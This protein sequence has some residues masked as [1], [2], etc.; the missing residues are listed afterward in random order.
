M[1]QYK[2]IEWLDDKKA[3]RL[4]D[5][6]VLPDTIAFKDLDTVESVA[7]A[8]RN[9]TV[10]G[11]PAIGVTAAYGL[12]I[13]AWLEPSDE[14]GSVQRAVNSAAATLRAARPTAVNLAWALAEVERRVTEAPVKSAADFRAAL[15]ETANDMA[16]EDIA[17]NRAIGQAAMALMP[18]E[19]VTFIHHCNTGSLATVEYGTALGVIRAAHDSGLDVIVF[20]DET[21]PRFQGAR[22]TCWELQNEGIRHRLIVDGA[23]SHVMQRF[24]VDMCMVGTDRVAANGD[25]A[26]KVG[27]C[28]LAAAAKAHG[29]PFYVA[30]PLSSVD[31]DTPTGADIEIELRDPEEVSTINGSLLAPSGVEVYNPAFDITPAALV[32]AIITEKGI[33]YPP[34]EESLRKLKG[35]E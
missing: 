35:S 32:T 18:E 25:V 10:R 20:V 4:L 31:L 6:E 15:L 3:V 2:T 8:I 26:N 23:S 33:A 22:L 19:K 16:Q 5:Q 34:F 1:T 27:T 9:M 7:S 21:R 11:A 28:N 30:A 29:V 12:V 24:P 17:I 14:L 13:A